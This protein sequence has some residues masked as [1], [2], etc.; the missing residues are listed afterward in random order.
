MKGRTWVAKNPQHSDEVWATAKQ[1]NSERPGHGEWVP[2]EAVV[3]P[4]WQVRGLNDEKVREYGDVSERMPPIRVQK[5]T[6]VLIDGRHRYSAEPSDCVRIVEDPVED[7]NL[8][9]EQVRANTGHGLPYTREEKRRLIK[10][11]LK[12]YP[13]WSDAKVAEVVSCSRHTVNSFRS[14]VQVGHVETVREGRDG[15]VTNVAARVAAAPRVPARSFDPGPEEEPEPC[16]DCGEPSIDGFWCQGC[17]D[18]AAENMAAWDAETQ[19]AHAQ[20]HE[21]GADDDAAEDDDPWAL[22]VF[23]HLEDGIEVKATV[24]M[25]GEPSAEMR[26][27]SLEAAVAKIGPWLE[28]VRMALA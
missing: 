16:K 21:P 7:D 3:I 17:H 26:R 19:E 8:F 12:R 9:I 2:K 10:E 18:T 25:Y 11:L 14:H 5:H 23:C 22:D 15:R 13:Q 24:R 1:M 28:S 6:F 4:D 20:R 27:R